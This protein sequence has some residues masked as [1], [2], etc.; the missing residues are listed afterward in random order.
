MIRATLRKFRDVLIKVSAHQAVATFL[1]EPLADDVRV[2]EAGEPRLTEAGEL[3]Y[4]E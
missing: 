1:P 2:T 3:R 4:I